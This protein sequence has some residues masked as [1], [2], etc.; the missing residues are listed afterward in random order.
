[1]STHKIC[2]HKVRSNK[3]NY[4]NFSAQKSAYLE[5]W[6]TKTIILPV[7]TYLRMSNWYLSSLV[8][9]ISVISWGDCGHSVLCIF[10]DNI[11]MKREFTGNFCLF[12]WHCNIYICKK[13]MH[14]FYSFN[15]L[16]FSIQL[17]TK[18][19]S[20]YFFFFNFRWKYFYGYSA[21]SYKYI[22]NIFVMEK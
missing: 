16:M 11:I 5:L 12:L 13:S 15:L 19:E 17:I 1:M 14:N 7:I 3:K 10:W 4:H 18:G 6:Y 2:F 21:E 20:K 9:T 22:Q 8:T